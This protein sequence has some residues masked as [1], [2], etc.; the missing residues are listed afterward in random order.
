[1][2][3]S[4]KNDLA[5][6]LKKVARDVR[7]HEGGEWKAPLTINKSIMLYLK[8]YN[9]DSLQVIVAKY[10]GAIRLRMA[11]HGVT[12]IQT[13]MHLKA[14]FMATKDLRL[15]DS[16][17]HITEVKDHDKK[18]AFD[19]ELIEQINKEKYDDAVL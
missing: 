6:S 16:I 1:M 9:I 13:K 5:F 14:K 12:E 17:K 8:R 18:L 10:K 4:S 2:E 3:C 15:P 7:K 19:P 11:G